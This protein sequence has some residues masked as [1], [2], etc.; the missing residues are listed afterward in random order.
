MRLAALFGHDATEGDVVRALVA[1]DPAGLTLAEAPGGGREGNLT[2]LVF[3][4][5]D[6]GDVVG[7]T[8]E[9]IDVRLD[10]DAYN[11][12]PAAR[13]PLQRPP[14]VQEGGRLPDP[15]GRP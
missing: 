1:V 14:P 13:P 4:L 2:M 3:A 9:V 8:R 12:G 6:E 5:D 11:S 10:A 15:R 7:Q